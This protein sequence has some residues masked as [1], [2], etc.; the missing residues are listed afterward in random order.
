MPAIKAAATWIIEE[1]TERGGGSCCRELDTVGVGG[2]AEYAIGIK[3]E[4]AV[5]AAA[6]GRRNVRF[7]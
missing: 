1:A 3:A 5:G 4:A 7:L 2:K 6:G